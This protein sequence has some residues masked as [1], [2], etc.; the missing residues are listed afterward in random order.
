MIQLSA[1]KHLEGHDLPPGCHPREAEATLSLLGPPQDPHSLTLGAQITKHLLTFPLT[2]ARLNAVFKSN[3][4]VL[5][6]L[7]IL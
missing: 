5:L 2:V 3:R 1:I 7:A 6:T 4:S